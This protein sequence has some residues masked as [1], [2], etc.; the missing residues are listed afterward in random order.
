MFFLLFLGI[1]FVGA[2]DN[3]IFSLLGMTLSTLLAL[4]CFFGA[5]VFRKRTI[6]KKTAL[7]ESVYI[8]LSGLKNYL[9]HIGN[10]KD[11]NLDEITLW[12][13]YILYAIILDESK[14]IIKDAKKELKELKDIVRKLYKT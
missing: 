7:G 14:E 9:K 6:I 2:Y 12:D 4:A 3:V 5:E 11:K 13:E 1:F 10:F 8:K